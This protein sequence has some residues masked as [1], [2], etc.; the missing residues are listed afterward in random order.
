[1]PSRQHD[2][3]TLRPKLS[4]IAARPIGAARD[5][6]DIEVMLSDRGDV[7][8]GVAVDEGEF[9]GWVLSTECVDLIG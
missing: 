7:V 4:A 8:G 2:E 5:E 9:D 6:R 1:M 3:N